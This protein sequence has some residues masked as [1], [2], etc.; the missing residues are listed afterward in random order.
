M[1]PRQSRIQNQIV[2]AATKCFNKGFGKACHINDID[3]IALE[4]DD[5]ITAST[6]LVVEALPNVLGCCFTTL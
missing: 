6:F 3:Q 2:Q 4:H 5:D 1:K